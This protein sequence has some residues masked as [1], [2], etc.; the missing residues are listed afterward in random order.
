M[1]RGWAGREC[2][3][4]DVWRAGS[5][6][7]LLLGLFQN[8]G[9]AAQGLIFSHQ[10]AGCGGFG[11][12]SPDAV[13]AFEAH[14]TEG[15]LLLSLAAAGLC[16]LPSCWGRG[17]AYLKCWG[18]PPIP[19]HAFPPDAARGQEICAALGRGDG[20]HQCCN[21]MVEQEERGERTL[22][23]DLPQRCPELGRS[24]SPACACLRER[25]L[26]LLQAVGPVLHSHVPGVKV[27]LL[28]VSRAVT[29]DVHIAFSP[30][31]HPRMLNATGKG[32]AGE[33]Y[34]PRGIFWSLSSQT[35][36][37]VVTVLNIPQLGMFQEVNQTGQV[38][39]N[40][41]VGITVGETSISG[42]RDPVHLT[43]AHGQLPHGITPQCV[44]WDPSK[45]L[46]LTGAS[47]GL[48]VGAVPGS[49]GHHTVLVSGQ[50][51]GWSSS[52]CD[53]Q[54]WDKGTRC[55]CDHLTFF[56]LLLNPALDRS[57]AQALMAVATAGCGVAMAFSI[58]TIAF[59]IFFRCR[60]RSEETLRI[61][62]GLHVNLVGSLLLLNLA[63]LLNSRL[64]T[65]TLL[66][67]C[68]VLG[69]FTHYCL[70]CCFTWMALEGCHLYLLFVKVLGTYIRNYL[71]KLSLVGWGFPALVVGVAGAIGSYGEY[72]IQTTDHQVI[73]RLCWIT[74]KHL[75]V[76][77][78]TN[79]GYFG[80]IFLF[81]TA[82]F[83]VVIQKSCSLQSTG[84]VQG[85]RKAWKV[86]LVAMGL[87]CLLGATWAL[88]FLTHGT[89]SV[90]MLYLFTILN[91]L[92]GIFIFIW[93]V[94]LYYPKAKE[95][96]GS[97]SHIIRPDKATTAS[98]D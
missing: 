25:W 93:L 13:H 21:V 63:F 53:T 56:T 62:L 5:G 57:T 16:C 85:D 14:V 30:T 59:C 81:N 31:E 74:S 54:P 96:V 27:L 29:Q 18:F 98:Q 84:V 52:G 68:K 79:C 76:H 11:F 71:V 77:Y 87:F 89:S 83:G 44:F 49:W 48:G 95:T 15:L 42:L 67:P 1:I 8:L 37:V 38:L 40:T 70:L 36:H 6:V 43:F 12:S 19:L 17:S 94:V 58:F 72:S 46:I 80:L 3:C 4:W 91:S 75:L 32:K 92:Q 60:Y 86:A 69:G 51:G 41:V 50:A 7:G 78:I 2:S 65:G 28:N 73:A 22:S 26:R 82:V 33:I 61:N 88:A 90:A 97:F 35:V 24:G 55:S 47:L 23:P 9:P 10:G 34:L 64:S 39:D 20:Q 45:G 66:G